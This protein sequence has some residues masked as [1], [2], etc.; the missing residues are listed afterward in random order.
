VHR[1]GQT[2]LLPRDFMSFV[3]TS[4]SLQANDHTM[5]A[6]QP[7]ATERR[8]STVSLVFIPIV[9]VTA[10]DSRGPYATLHSRDSFVGVIQ[11]VDTCLSSFN[12]LV[13][14]GSPV[15][16]TAHAMASNY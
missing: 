2:F 16:G 5:H 7:V 4:R 3:E 14:N 15:I 1:V 10:T 9:L 11:E 8:R 12:F 13:E 6:G